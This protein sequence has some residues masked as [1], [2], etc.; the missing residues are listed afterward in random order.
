MPRNTA[1]R[2]ATIRALAIAVG[3]TCTATGN[4]ATLRIGLSADPDSLDP[5]TPRVWVTTV[6]LNAICDKLID[7]T[8]DLRYVPQLATEWSWSQDGKALQLK[9]RPGVRFHDGEPLDAAAVKYSIDR[10]RTMRGSSYQAA[11]SPIAGVDVVDDMTVR[12]NLS[13]PLSGPLLSR[14]VASAGMIVSPKA[15]E[16]AGDKFGARPVCAG[17]YRFV[18]RVAQDHITLDRFTDYWDQSRVHIDRIV[19]RIMPDST[20]RLANLRAGALDLIEQV[21]PSDLQTIAQDA[22]VRAASATSLGHSRIYINVGRSDRAGAPLGRDARI[23]QAFNLTIDRDAINQVIFGGEYAPAN[24]W[25][26]PTSPLYLKQIPVARRDVARAKALLAAAGEPH[27]RIELML[28]NVPVQLQ[29]AEMIQAMAREAGFDLKLLALETATAVNAAD[30]GNYEAA[31]I[32]WPGFVDPDANIYSML[33]CGAPLN[34]GGYCNREV[35]RLLDAARSRADT[36][37]RVRL[38]TRVREILAQD[39]P[40][41]F[42]YHQ[43]W[44]W[45]HSAKLRGFVA[46]PDGVMRPL[47]LKLD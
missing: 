19:Y 39:E 42:L 29:V 3:L 7:V 46:H 40:Y 33:A 4:A 20:V 21:P 16:A 43:K 12:V 15:A 9:L 47:G 5:T 26:P 24:S 45:A 36:E 6:V 11:L 44:I 8:P 1:G 2:T 30:K 25:I 18:E 10:H 27:P 31:L 13:S 23:R 22:R 17:P 41:I 35:D 34:Y 38:Y 14:F 28:L 32:G 37:E